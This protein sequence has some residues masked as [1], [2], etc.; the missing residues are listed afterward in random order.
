V[1]LVNVPVGIAIA[2]LTPTQVHETERHP[3]RIDFAGAVT[4]TIG[5]TSLVYAFIRA[6]T[7]R[8]CA[9][10]ALSARDWRSCP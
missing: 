5:V 4:G 6:A 10:T 9:A 2:A 1:L 3:G 7:C 8:R